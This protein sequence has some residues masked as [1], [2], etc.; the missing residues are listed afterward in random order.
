[1]TVH[2]NEIELVRAL[3]AKADKLNWY[4]CTDDMALVTHIGTCAIHVY[5]TSV[6]IQILSGDFFTLTVDTELVSELYDKAH[7]GLQTMQTKIAS[8]IEELQYL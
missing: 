2:A 1:M 3:I 7:K 5:P 4:A 8:I 6:S